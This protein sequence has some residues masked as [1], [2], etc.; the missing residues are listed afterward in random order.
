MGYSDL[1]LQYIGR[2]ASA[3]PASGYVKVHNKEQDK[4]L[5]TAF[6]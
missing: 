2:K 1:G 3:S 4:I 5:T 6:E